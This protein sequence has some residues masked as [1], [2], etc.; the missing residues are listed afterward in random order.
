[1]AQDKDYSGR[2]YFFCGIG[3][4]GMLPLA[5]ILKGKGAKV[6]GSDRSADQ[7]R[8]P[9]KFDFLSGQGIALFPQDGSGVTADSVVRGLGRGGRHGAGHGGGQ[10]RWAPRL[11]LRAALLAELFNAAGTQ[12]RRG[13]HQRQIHHHRH[14]RLGAG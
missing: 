13:G 1:M 7:G 3:G 6:S 11:M 14:D 10:A 5:L 8:T 2:A 12:H 4:S 9:E